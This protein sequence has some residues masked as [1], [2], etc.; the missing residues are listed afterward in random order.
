MIGLAVA[1]LGSFAAFYGW[2]TSQYT[3][4]YASFASSEKAEAAGAE[5]RAIGLD[6]DEQTGSQAQSASSTGGNWIAVT[7]SNGETGEDAKPFRSAFR[8]IVARGDGRLDHPG[9]GCIE[10]APFN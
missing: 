7:F 2:A 3:E 6:A 4:C 5:A 1:L 9:G 8:S 10:R